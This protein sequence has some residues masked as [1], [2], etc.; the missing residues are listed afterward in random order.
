MDRVAVTQQ[1]LAAGED[2][3]DVAAGGETGDAEFGHVGR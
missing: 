1:R 3:M 2:G